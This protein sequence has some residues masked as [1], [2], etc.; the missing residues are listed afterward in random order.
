MMEAPAAGSAPDAPNMGLGLVTA[1]FILSGAA[2][3]IYQAVW[4]RELVLIYGNTSQA[5]STIVA[6]FMA[7]LGFGGLAGAALARRTRNPLRVYGAVE[8]G[9]AVLAV[10][11]PLGFN[12][13]GGAYASIYAGAPPAT[14][15]LVRFGLTAMVISP[16]TFLMGMTLPLLTAHL[17]RELKAAGPVLGRLYAANTLGATVGT[18][19]GG[20]VLIEFLGLTGTALVAVCLNIGAGTGGLLL[21]RGATRPGSRPDPVTSSARASVDR[22]QAALLAATFVSG[23]AALALE[24][25]WTRSIAEG[26]GSRIYTFLAVLVL[27]LVGTTIGSR[28]YEFRSARHDYDTGTLARLF[29]ATG[30]VALLSMVIGSMNPVNLGS[31]VRALGLLASVLV[32][33]ALMGFTFPLTARLLT[34]SARDAGPSVGR[35]YAVNT[36]GGILGAFAATFLLASLVGTPMSILL[37]GMAELATAA[38]LSLLVAGAARAARRRAAGFTAVAILGAIIAAVNPSVVRTST[39]NYL[40]TL[41]TEHT[42]AE[43]D[44]ATVDANGGALANRDLYVGGV[45]MTRL[46]VDTKLMGYLPSVVRPGAHRFLVIAFGMGSTYRSSLIDGAQTDAV[47]LSPSVPRQMHIFFP[48][49]VSYLGNP[50]GRV[51]IADGR[52]YVRLSK[53]HYDSIAVDPPPPVETAGSVVLYTQEFFVQSKQRLNPGGVMMLWIP[54]QVP[55]DDY[56]AHLRTFRSAFAHVTVILSPGQLGTYLYGS[57][58]PIDFDRT[59]MLAIMSRPEVTADLRDAPDPMPGGPA[60]WVDRVEQQVWLRDGDVDRFVG[61]GPLITDDHPRS[62]YFLWRR[63]LSGDNAFVTEP[64]LRTAAEVSAP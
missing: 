11:V 32:A 4:S 64:R 13:I 41:S 27:Y 62:E 39:Q 43:D 46:T 50:A 59:R 15:A 20:F 52:N 48:D 29:G 30:F 23:F 60:A 28:R 34:P 3:L 40:D 58:A 61:P 44:I 35:M 1:A 31:V 49:A 25:L 9:V 42:H 47:D 22:S 24:V 56:R 10:L 2:G 17:V 63:L 12:Q 8:V 6:A 7:G 16:A 26:T 53:E 57:D 21:S 18:L 19:V 45:S 36:L 38:A 33:S 14:L 55:L 5:V 54:D 51:I 37:I